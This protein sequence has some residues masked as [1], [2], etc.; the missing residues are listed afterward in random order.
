MLTVVGVAHQAG[1]V[2]GLQRRDMEQIVKISDSATHRGKQSNGNMATSQAGVP[3]NAGKPIARRFH[4]EQGMPKEDPSRW[5]EPDIPIDPADRPDLDPDPPPPP[6]G[7]PAEMPPDATPS[8]PGHGH[9][10]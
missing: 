9:E 1:N 7:V 8:H 6:G 5:T 2:S 3:P 4:T 10:A